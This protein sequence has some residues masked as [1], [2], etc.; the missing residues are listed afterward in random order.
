MNEKQ[1]QLNFDKGITN[2]PSDTIC[3]DNTLDES[4]GIIYD[5]GEHRVI[6]NPAILFPEEQQPQYDNQLLL[7]IHRFATKERWIFAEKQQVEAYHL[8]WYYKNADETQLIHGGIL[9]ENRQNRTFNFSEE[10]IRNHAFKIT[11]IGNSLVIIDQNGIA[12]HIWKDTGY[13]DSV[14][15]PQPQ[16]ELSLREFTYQAEP[17]AGTVG[18]SMMKAD[19][20]LSSRVE[21]QEKYNNLVL[22]LYAR[23]LKQISNINAFC[24]PF[25]ARVALQLYDGSYHYISQPVMMFAC[26]TENSHMEKYADGVGMSTA[27]YYLYAKQLTD[28]SQLSDVVKNVSIFVSDGIEPHDLTVDQP[29]SGWGGAGTSERPAPM[30]DAVHAFAAS[31]NKDYY[32]EHQL[33]LTS[34]RVVTFLKRKE[35]TD[36]KAE[37]ETTSV[38]YKLCDIGLR[39]IDAFTNLKS[40]IKPHTLTNITTQEQLPY[41]DYF[42]RCTIKPGVAYAYNNRL[43][44]ANV[45]RGFFQGYGYFLPFKGTI[46]A[47]LHSQQATP[48]NC[49]FYVTIQTSE[50]QYTVKHTEY[51]SDYQGIFFYYPDAR[52]KHV[53][54]LKNGYVILDAELTE[55]TGLNGAYYFKGLPGFEGQEE[56]VQNASVPQN[57]DNNATEHLPDHILTSEVNNPFTFKAE[58]YNQVGTGRIIALSTITQALSQG[59]FGQFPLLVFSESGIWAMAVANTGTF[60]SIH[61][62]SREVCNNPASITQTDGAVFFTSEKGLMLVIGSDVR[63]VSEQLSGK[64]PGFDGVTSMGNFID[65][66]RQAFMAYDYRDSMLWIFKPRH[67]TCYVYAINSGTFAKYTF[68]QYIDTTVN[69]Y[70]DFIMQRAEQ[71]TG[72]LYSLTKRPNINLDTTLYS[73]MMITRPMK[74]ENALALKSI[75]QIRH[76]KDFHA[77]ECPAVYP[78]EETAAATEASASAIH[79]VSPALALR[80]F[81][82]NNLH[83]WA[84]LYSLRGKPWKYYRFRFDFNNL[85]ATDRYAGTILITQER[86]TNKL[87]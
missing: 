65:Y 85:K 62:M 46:D 52:A 51:A 35:R 37:L 44:I 33:T 60:A 15:I 39:S 59:Q 8:H 71:E 29:F 53:V 25:L 83:T 57:Y 24:Q 16:F 23:N 4:L 58:G 82:S 27:C 14:N 2:I 75:L 19:G 73:A 32:Q 13:S 69:Y 40:Y 72:T 28:Y 20:I 79:S 61:P 38:F 50:G 9:T 12:Y 70:P 76:I 64:E 66:L 42:S 74:L 54:I 77:P 47:D 17:Q 45:Q 56:I 26:V 48:A 43:N 41:D 21:D 5:S 10:D 87:R 36:I 30:Y 3:S 67:R 68:P 34:T 63:C 22:G 31:S 11:A 55:H 49:D 18:F 1:Q 78:P 80:V 84:E 86:R 7:Y 6:Q 81:A